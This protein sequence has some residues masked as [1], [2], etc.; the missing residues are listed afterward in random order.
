MHNARSRRLQHTS[1]QSW[2]IL[3]THRRARTIEVDDLRLRLLNFKKRNRIFQHWKSIVAESY[4]FSDPPQPPRSAETPRSRFHHSGRYDELLRK[5]RALLLELRN[6]RLCKFAKAYLVGSR[7][8][9]YRAD[10]TRPLIVPA[11][12]QLFFRMAQIVIGTCFYEFR[13]WPAAWLFP[14]ALHLITQPA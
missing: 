5:L 10:S 7:K 4:N 11:S 6:S 2:K 14:S 13:F 9:R 3:L 8:Q 1:F 12:Q